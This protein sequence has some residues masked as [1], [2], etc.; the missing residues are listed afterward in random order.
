MSDKERE[1]FQKYTGTAY[2]NINA[3]LRGIDKSFDVGNRENAKIFMLY[4]KMHLC[5]VKVRFIGECLLM[6]WAS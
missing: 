3:T 6:H 5:H 2:V 4:W 1:A